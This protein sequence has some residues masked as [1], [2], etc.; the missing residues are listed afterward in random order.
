MLYSKVLFTYGESMGMSR[1]C[2]GIKMTP[3]YRAKRIDTN[4]WVYGVPVDTPE[5]EGDSKQ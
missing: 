5:T 4:N 2:G 1:M 3:K